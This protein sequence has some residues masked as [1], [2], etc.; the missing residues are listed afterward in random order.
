MYP[1]FSFTISKGAGLSQPGLGVDQV[2]KNNDNDFT[3]IWGALHFSQINSFKPLQLV[4]PRLYREPP[5]LRDS[6]ENL[7]YILLFYLKDFKY[8]GTSYSIVGNTRFQE[9]IAINEQQALKWQR[10]RESVYLGSVKHFLKSVIDRKVYQ[11]GFKVF[12]RKR[13]NARIVLVVTFREKQSSHSIPRH[14]INGHF[15][16]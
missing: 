9:M 7:G 8:F 6:N 12:A 1:R 10:N 4:F 14:Y 5:R 15:A 2:C 3:E 16:Q 11:E 13:L